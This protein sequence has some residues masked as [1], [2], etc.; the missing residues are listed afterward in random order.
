MAAIPLD[1][2]IK[3][4]VA[5]WREKGYERASIVTQRL[6]E[7]WFKEEHWLKDGSEF[8]FWRAQRE[9]IEALI[10]VYEVCRYHNLYSLARN[11]GVSLTFDPTTDNWPKYCFKMATGSGK[12]F[13]MALAMVWQYFNRF[14]RTD[15]GCRYTSHFLLI[16]PNLI[17]LDRLNEAFADNAIFNEFPFIPP[18][19]EAD[20]GLQLVY[21]SQV[22][23]PHAFGILYL[24]NVQQLYEDKADEPTNEV[25]EAL[26][27]YV[28]KGQPL[29]RIDLEQALS[30]HRDL[31]VLNDEAHHVHS[32]DL[33]W[34]KAINR[35][36]DAGHAQSGQGLV[37]QL[38]FS[39]APYTGAGDRKVF[40]PHTI[41]DY[42][43]AAAIRDQVV[44][45][46]KI[47]E[48]E[49]APE[50]LTKD[51]VKRNR[52]Q[53][54][55]GVEVFRRF[56]RD[57][58]PTGKKPVLF[59]MADQTRNADKVGAYLEREHRLK[60]LVIHTDTAGV[61]TKKDLEKAREAA[62]T[63]D[64]NEYEAIVSVMMLKEGWDVKN[65]CVIVP[66][67]SYESAILAEQTLGRGLRRMS[68]P[69]AEWEEKL[70]VIDHPR[71][72]DL[73]NAEIQNEDLDIE[74]TEAHRVYEPANI[75][76]VDPA[77]VQYDLSIPVLT[78]GITRDVRKIADLD[79][80]TLPAGLFRFD[81]IELPRVM[82]REKDLLTQKTDLERELSFDYTDRY[83]IYLANITKAILSRCA[84]SAQFAEVVPKV[85]QYIE[86]RLFDKRVDM[87]NPD[88]VRKLNHLPVREKIRDVFT[89]AILRLQVVEEPYQFVERFAASQMESFHTSEPVYP[90]K[91]T[92][93]EVLPYPRG[94]EYEKHFMQYL[95]EQD[96][97]LAYT[98]V[99]PR[100]PL[101]I[102]YHDAQGHLRHYTPDFVAKTANGYFL[103]EPKGAGWDQHEDTPAKVQAAM[104]WCQKVS[105]L[106]GERWT[107]VKILQPDFERFQG[108]SFDQLISACREHR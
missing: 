76:R 10:Y 83:D 98:K 24:T 68:Q 44:K 106:T 61:I 100:M 33:E 30:Q 5:A 13:V 9:A 90:A 92:V 71:F 79:V 40:F 52:L 66:L 37:M 57:F 18:E 3:S 49:H 86:Q 39:A 20:F 35:L 58:K 8:T 88:I 59:V 26:G 51:Y 105:D 94:F 80:G 46:P 16:A 108:L 25:Q 95:D 6:L 38:D 32:D 74:I 54:D 104:E 81:E 41:Y 89:D 1:H 7:F 87:A 93:F 2:K 97:V 14:F 67:R 101:R 47:G 17:V 62:R 84:A 12:T 73:W 72:R 23:A 55:T 107:F 78:G 21:Q 77:K 29:S 64:T 63:I 99:L 60:T 75:V 103:L 19:W 22:T 27:P 28:V 56:Q 91:K 43:L 36:H 11:F 96:E 4:A 42:P 45:R 85:R 102:P 53:I 70:I 65:V 15:N 82:Y 48:I 34:A 69:H 31:L 50:P